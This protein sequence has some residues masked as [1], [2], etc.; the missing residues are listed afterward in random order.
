V[1]LAVLAVPLFDMVCVILGRLWRRENPMK[2]D[3]TS[4]LAHRMLARGV[5]PGMVVAFAAG[6]TALTG[7]ASV[8]MYYLGGAQLVGAWIVVAAALAAVFIARR[9]AHAES[10]P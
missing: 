6:V 1:P 9:P 3:A 2:G 5:S 4:H 8:A 7:G 10:A